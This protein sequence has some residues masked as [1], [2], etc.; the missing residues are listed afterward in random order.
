MLP[1][2]GAWAL[3]IVGI[4]SASA[5]ANRAHAILN[6]RVSAESGELTMLHLGGGLAGDMWEIPLYV[7]T[8]RAIEPA[9]DCW[10]YAVLNGRRILVLSTR[11]ENDAS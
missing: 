10:T 3:A 4:I 9:S 5:L 6:A 7:D 8:G 2:L 1:H 11:S